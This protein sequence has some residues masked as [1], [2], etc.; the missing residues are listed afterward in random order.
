MPL[1]GRRPRLHSRLTFVCSLIKYNLVQFARNWVCASDMASDFWAGPRP[2]LTFQKSLN[3]LLWFVTRY[4]VA[5]NWVSLCETT[6][7]CRISTTNKWNKKRASDHPPSR[8]PLPSSSQF[9]PKEPKSSYLGQLY[10]SSEKRI[11]GAS[12][13]SRPRNHWMYMYVG[14]GDWLMI[15]LK[16]RETQNAITLNRGRRRNLEA[17]R[18]IPMRRP[19]PWLSLR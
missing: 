11:C 3:T 8:L 9:T 12:W 10:T 7:T 15:D 17:T 19:M 13:I 1:S 6:Q 16:I 18:R 4:G 14:I 2:A 5:A